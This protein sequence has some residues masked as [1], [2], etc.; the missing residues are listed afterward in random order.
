M[1]AVLFVAA[2]VML[3]LA[4]QAGV[5]VIQHR[6]PA[7]GKA[8]EVTGATLNVLDIGPR[9]PPVRRSFSFTAQAQIW[10]RCAGRWATGSLSATA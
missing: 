1:L 8:I 9:T 6:F 10:K 4:T 7:Q 3:A 5:I 2:L